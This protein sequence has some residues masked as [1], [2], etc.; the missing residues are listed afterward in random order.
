M[1]ATVEERLAEVEARLDALQRLLGET[2]APTPFPTA[3]PSR[4][5]GKQRGW[6][7]V[8]GTFAD[9]PLYEEAMRLGKEWRDAQ[10]DGAPDVPDAAEPRP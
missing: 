10:K 1:A 2:G 7:A 9:D 3:L 4:S 8:V 6:R 5:G